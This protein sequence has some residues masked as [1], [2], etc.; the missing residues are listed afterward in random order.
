MSWLLRVPWWKG[1]LYAKIPGPSIRGQD[2]TTEDISEAYHFLSKED[3]MAEWET[4]WD[5]D[6]PEPEYIQVG[7]PFE[8][9]ALAAERAEKTD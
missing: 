3:A 7:S 9:L 2:H 6:L 5:F 1:H 8:D 4:Y